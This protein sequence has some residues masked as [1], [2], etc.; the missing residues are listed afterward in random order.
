MEKLKS[1]SFIVVLCQ[2]I[3]VPKCLL[4]YAC[5]QV[6]NI[7][8]SSTLDKFKNNILESPRRIRFESGMPVTYIAT[9]KVNG[10]VLKSRSYQ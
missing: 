1:G 3:P 9:D 8:N 10:I 7:S 6:S 4:V 5:I 2:N